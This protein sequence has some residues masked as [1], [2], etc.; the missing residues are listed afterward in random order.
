MLCMYKL[1]YINKAESGCVYTCPGCNSRLVVHRGIKNAQHFKHYR[2]APCGGETYLHNVAKILFF[3]NYQ[4]ALINQQPFT[5]TLSQD[6]HCIN[7][8]DIFSKACKSSEVVNFDLTSF[9]DCVKLEV[10]YNDFKPDVLL[11][12]SAHKEVLFIEIA[13]THHCEQNKINSGYRIIEFSIKNE[14]DL[15]LLKQNTITPDDIYIKSYNINTLPKK[16][17]ICDSCTLEESI[18]GVDTSGIIRKLKGTRKSIG[19]EFKNGDI[20]AHQV[21]NPQEDL[22]EVLVSILRI[23]IKRGVSVPNCHLCLHASISTK[24]P[25]VYCL[26]K[27]IEVPYSEAD[28]CFQYNN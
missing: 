6:V 13:V 26:K 22:A 2:K 23:A 21:L 11:S 28:L 4:L 5:I 19:K 18:L 8:I 3:N 7:Y 27:K 25:Q 1:I 20:V 24:F 16:T 10:K 17:S 14:D 15:E 12:S 9:F